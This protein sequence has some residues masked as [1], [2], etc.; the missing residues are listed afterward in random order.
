M[1][2][3]IVAAVSAL[4]AIVVVFLLKAINGPWDGDSSIRTA[5]VGAVCGVVS[6]AVARNLRR[7]GG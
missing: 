2:L 5:I 3:L 7:E 6:T 1:K 4:T